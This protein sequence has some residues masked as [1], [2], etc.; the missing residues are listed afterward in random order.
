[1]AK[2][3]AT[4]DL[5]IIHEIYLQIKNI[6][7]NYAKRFPYFLAA[8]QYSVPDND[9][10]ATLNLRPYGVLVEIDISSLETS[11]KSLKNTSTACKNPRSIGFY[12]RVQS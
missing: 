4:I 5:K 3:I 11:F 6:Y 9:L 8:C 1:M 7:P 12:T 10:E 2:T